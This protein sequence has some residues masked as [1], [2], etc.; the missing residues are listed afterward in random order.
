MNDRPIRHSRT[1]IALILLLAA[2]PAFADPPTPAA[3]ATYQN[4]VAALEARLTRQHASAATFLAGLPFDSENQG[5]LHQGEL[6][7]D[8]LTPPDGAP[9]PGALL[10]HWRA[11]AFVPG[12]TAD[13]FD[14]LLRDFPAYPRVFAR[15]V[16]AARAETPTGE[17]VAPRNYQVL[18]RV[19]QHHV[20]T[21]VLETAYD[22]AFVQLDPQHRSSISRSTQIAEIGSPGTPAEHA[23]SP[24]DDHGYLWRQ[25]TYWS[26]E[27]RDGGLYL[28][29]ESVSLTRSIPYGLGW[30]VGPYIASVPR[31]SLTFTLGAA[32][33]ALR[34]SP[35]PRLASSASRHDLTPHDL[36][37]HERTRP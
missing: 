5:R 25:N 8:D 10:H 22:V 17:P 24:S 15:Q 29:I 9:L 36:N 23:L 11:T 35:G 33:A 26:W 13:A 7:I 32:A 31:D 30:A 20:L 16:I 37:P 28:Q 21:V 27:E 2:V 34:S 12:A 19:R 1:L 3:L 4:Y 6:L 18:L 14:R